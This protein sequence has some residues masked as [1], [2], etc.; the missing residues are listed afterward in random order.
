M[1]S[2]ISSYTASLIKVCTWQ[3]LVLS[4]KVIKS[5]WSKS[6]P[7]GKKQQQSSLH[8][9]LIA[10]ILTPVQRHKTVLSYFLNILLI[11]FVIYLQRKGFSRL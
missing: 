10:V 1:R 8:N 2:F 11:P 5:G 7:G 4:Y 6:I 9:L 3:H